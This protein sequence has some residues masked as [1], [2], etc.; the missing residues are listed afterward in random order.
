MKNLY[1]LNLKTY[2]TDFIISSIL[3]CIAFYFTYTVSSIIGVVLTSI[4]LYRLCAF[5]HEIAH[6]NKNP[7]IKWFKRVW[8]LTGGL[9][10]LQPSI[11]FTRPHLKHHTSGIFATKDDPQ[12]PLIFSKP[13][14]AFTIFVVLPWFLPVYN[15]LK[16][17]FPQS[18]FLHSILYK[19]IKFSETEEA[20]A[21]IYEIYYLL[22]FCIIVIFNPAIIYTFY[23]VSVGAWMLSVLRIPLEHPLFEYKGTSTV[24]DQEVLSYTHE[25]PIYI[26]VQPLALRYH[27]AHHMYPKIP[28]HNLPDYYYEL[29]RTDGYD[30]T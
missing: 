1:K 15:L 8:N 14:L 18:P 2:W 5:T 28:Y 20:E 11:R 6:Q 29:K 3:F 25:S 13:A 21:R 17:I 27:K 9:L 24:Q 26:P 19:G 30:P 4:F 16:A 10:M 23:F 12:Y 7:Q 22:C